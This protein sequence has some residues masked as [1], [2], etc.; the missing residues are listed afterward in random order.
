MRGFACGKNRRTTLLPYNYSFSA[1]TNPS[2]NA[3]LFFT[4]FLNTKR[5]AQ[6]CTVL[7]VVEIEGLVLKRSESP[8]GTSDIF[9]Y[10]EIGTISP[11]PQYTWACVFCKIIA[12]QNAPS[13]RRQGV[14]VEIEGFEPATSAM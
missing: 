9:Q 14:M 1:A 11:S 10:H 6:K 2:I 7:F 12:K 4:P 5:T 3:R 13:K 8:D